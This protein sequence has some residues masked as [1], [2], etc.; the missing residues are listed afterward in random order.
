MGQEFL[1][2][3]SL[4]ID[5]IVDLLDQ[6]AL[7]PDGSLKDASEIPWVDD[8]DDEIPASASSGNG[9]YST[10]STSFI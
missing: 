6:C 8:L 7:R 1:S 9:I 3:P 10:I 4:I 2:S 5:N